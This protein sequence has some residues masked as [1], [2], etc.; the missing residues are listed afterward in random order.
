MR[1]ILIFFA[2]GPAERERIINA[3]RQSVFHRKIRDRLDLFGQ[4]R[5]FYIEDRLQRK[6]KIRLGSDVLSVLGRKILDSA[7][8]IF[9]GVETFY[10]F[11]RTD[12]INLLAIQSIT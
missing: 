11:N 4:K 5:V 10:F 9:V 6:T 8:K 3:R 1:E 7:G 2:H 12:Q